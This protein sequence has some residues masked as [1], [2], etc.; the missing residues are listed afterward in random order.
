MQPPAE[1]D[2]ARVKKIEQSLSVNISLK[3]L[4]ALAVS[5]DVKDMESM[6]SIIFLASNDFISICS[7]GLSNS[8]FLL[9]PIFE[10]LS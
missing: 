8:F 2:P 6:D 9:C 1:V 4:D 7:I 3:I 5:L 10:L